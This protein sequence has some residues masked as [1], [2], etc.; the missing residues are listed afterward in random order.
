VSHGHILPRA[1][2]LPSPLGMFM[3]LA[4]MQQLGSEMRWGAEGF[5]EEL[6][7]VALKAASVDDAGV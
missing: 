7:D 3:A 6:L 2:R 5:F 4:I 1:K